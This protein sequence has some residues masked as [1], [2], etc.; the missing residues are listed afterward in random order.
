M[1]QGMNDLAIHS[2]FELK[3]AIMNQPEM[4]ADFKAVADLGLPQ[5]CIAA[6]YIRNFVWD[7]QHGYSQNTPLH[8]VD[9]LYFDPSCLNEEVEKEYDEA[10]RR[11]RPQRNWSAK[12]QARMHL[13]NGDQPYC[14]VE[15]AML[16]WPETATAIGARLVT[17]GNIELIAP[18]GL[19]DLLELRVRQSPYFRDYATFKQRV[20]SKGWLQIWPRLRLETDIKG[21]L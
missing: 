14:S 8:D 2:A 10:L 5:G 13:K 6:G 16:H 12:N 3:Q 7:L 11:V 20:E 21:G 19:D 18:F 15:E 9:V 4:I 1:I 17:D